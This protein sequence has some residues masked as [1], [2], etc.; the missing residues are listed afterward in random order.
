MHVCV[1]VRVCVHACVRACVCVCVCVRTRVRD[2]CVCVCVSVIIYVCVNGSDMKQ[3]VND[4][5]Y[6]PHGQAL[7]L[8]GNVSIL[9]P[10]AA[11]MISQVQWR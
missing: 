9:F 3:K 1:C 8:R 6:R 4:S 5:L 11:T 2:V 10:V 7:T